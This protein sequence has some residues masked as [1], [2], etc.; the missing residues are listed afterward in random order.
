MR[1]LWDQVGERLFETGV[2]NGVLYPIN[3]SNEYKPGVAWNGLTAVNESPSGAE[4]TALYADNVKYLNLMSAETFG[5]T[6]EAYTYPDEFAACDGSATIAKGA[7]IGQ[8]PRKT[9]GF[10]YRTLIGNDIVGQDYGYKLHLVYGCLASPSEQS[11]ATVNESPE[12]KTFSWSI[13]TT[14]VNVT[15]FKATSHLV[16]DSTVVDEDKLTALENILY[17]QD[18]ADFDA[19]KTYEVG[20]LVKH[21]TKTYKCIVAVETPA[22][23]NASDWEE[24]D[25]DIARLPLPNEVATLLAAG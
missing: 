20:D 18:V 3:N 7:T 22:E 16:V 8:Q 9:F 12:A 10:C 5:A 1:L 11:N 21:E 19:S 2:D 25:A 24:S 13:S 4:P 14:P 6:I 15:G 23:W 17:G